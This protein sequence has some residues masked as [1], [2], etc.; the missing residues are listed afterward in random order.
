LHAARNAIEQIASNDT[1]LYFQHDQLDSTRLLTDENG[2]V[3]ASFS[4]DAYGTL[5]RKGGEADTLLRWNGQYQDETGL[6]YLRARYYDPQTAQFLTRDPLEP[7]T[8]EPY[9]YV[10]GNP[11]NWAD[12]LG[13]GCGLH[14][15]SWPVCIG[16]LWGA[17]RG[18]AEDVSAAAAVAATLL[19][20]PAP[21]LAAVAEGISLATGAIASGQAIADKNYLSA[22][23]DSLAA[24]MG[25]IGTSE[26]LSAIVLQAGNEAYAILEQLRLTGNSINA[27]VLGEELDTLSRDLAVL[28]AIA[29]HTTDGPC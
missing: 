26:R 28:I 24:A 29:K 17:I 18:H 27:K 1:P 25:G 20:G 3:A 7:L 8:Q 12:P 9:G 19:V 15:I 21:E 13:L 22:L 23:A 10:Y 11:L 14:P 2:M 16:D 5:I 6:Y 4:Y